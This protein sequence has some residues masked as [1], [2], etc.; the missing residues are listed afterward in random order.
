MGEN[1]LVCVKARV[2]AIGRWARRG[3]RGRG[4]GGELEG[5]DDVVSAKARAKK[6]ALGRGHEGAGEEARARQRLRDRETKTDRK[7]ETDRQT[8]R[9]LREEKR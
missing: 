9:Q 5:E 2:R 6:G 8:D 4:Q 3:P 1:E 7:T